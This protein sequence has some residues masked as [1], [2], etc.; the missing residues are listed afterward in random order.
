M[1]MRDAA[2]LVLWLTTR[3]FLVS[4]SVERC[5]HATTLTV[6]E[7]MRPSRHQPISFALMFIVISEGQNVPPN[8][9]DGHKPSREHLHEHAAQT[10]KQDKKKRWMLLL[11]QA[12]HQEGCLMI[13]ATSFTFNCGIRCQDTNCT[14]NS[15]VPQ[16]RSTHAKRLAFTGNAAVAAH[17]VARQ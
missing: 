11:P 9:I 1:S 15:R 13:N 7:T 4:H 8:S 12:T 2:G 6:H 3:R 10:H 5:A 17:L 14:T 16:P